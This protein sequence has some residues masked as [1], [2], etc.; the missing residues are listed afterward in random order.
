MDMPTTCPECGEIVDFN[1][2]QPTTGKLS[3]HAFVCEYCYDELESD[4]GE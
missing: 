2:M 3:Y 1:D 4:E